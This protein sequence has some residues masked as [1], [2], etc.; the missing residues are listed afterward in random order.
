VVV[1]TGDEEGPAAALLRILFGPGGSDQGSDEGSEEEDEED[2][3]SIPEW[4]VD[5]TG[6]D[7]DDEDDREEEDLEANSDREE[8]GAD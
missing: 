7:D 2:E 5:S 8:G 3:S 4:A 6:G 1:E